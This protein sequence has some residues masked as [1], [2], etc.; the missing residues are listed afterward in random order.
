[1]HGLEVLLEVTGEACQR[2]DP[3]VLRLVRSTTQTDHRMR[4]MPT[5]DYETCRPAIPE[6]TDHRLRSMPSSLT[7]TPDSVVA[8]PRNPR[9]DGRRWIPNGHQG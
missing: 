1:M 6:Q 3:A 8:M 7:G 5:T 9:Q 4:S 2:R